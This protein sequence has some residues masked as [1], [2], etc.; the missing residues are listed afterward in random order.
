M[1]G[2]GLDLNDELGLL[3]LGLLT[4]LDLLAGDLLKLLEG[5][6][7]LL[8]GLLLDD[9]DELRDPPDPYF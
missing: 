4:L 9:G 7:L 5:L 8:L 6:L 1:A 3:V 2:G